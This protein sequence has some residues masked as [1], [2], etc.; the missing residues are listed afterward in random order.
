MSNTTDQDVVARAEAY[1]D[2]DDAD[3]FYYR[4]WGGED[5]HIGL[6]DDASTPIREASRRTVERMATYLEGLPPDSH[7]IDLGAGYG[8]AARYLTENFG[9]KVTCLNLSRVQNNRNR[10]FNAERGLSEKIDVIDGNFEEVPCPDDSFAFIWS[11][12]SFLHSGKRAQI[13]REMDRLLK[14]GGIVVFTDPMQQDGLSR[15]ELAP[16]LARIHLDDM[17]SVPRYEAYAQELGWEK[18]A[19]EPM[20]EQLVNHYGRV[21]QELEKNEDDIRPY[22]QPDYVERMKTG[23]D[24]WVSFGKAGKLDW[25]I[26]VFRK[27][28]N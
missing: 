17:G 13:F 2:S 4:I 22:V 1:Y 24:H 3:N 25:G 14:P 20:P 10:E 16:V 26:L 8:G 11:Q 15:D 9:F 12:D 6:Y 7:G 28:A 5:I 21:K 18:V 27:P 23:L 19:H